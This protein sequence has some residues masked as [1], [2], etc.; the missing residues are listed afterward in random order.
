MSWFS[1]YAGLDF[2]PLT[3][4]YNELFREQVQT[5]RLYFSLVKSETELGVDV[6]QGIWKPYTLENKNL[7]IQVTRFSWI[8]IKRYPD[9][10]TPQFLLSSQIRQDNTIIF[11]A[12]LVI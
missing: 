4:K 1:Q 2:E 7:D 12:P 3:H 10:V 11:N 9:Y 6:G 8:G 5:I